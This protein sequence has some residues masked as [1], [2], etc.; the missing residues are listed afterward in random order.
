M[1]NIFFHRKLN[2]ILT[3][4]EPRS[5][6]FIKEWRNSL[7]NVDE[8]DEKDIRI[9]ILLDFA[10]ETYKL[11]QIS[12]TID[13]QQKESS[14]LSG[15]KSVNDLP[16]CRINLLELAKKLCH[17]I[18]PSLSEHLINNLSCDNKIKDILFGCIKEDDPERLKKT[19]EEKNIDYEYLAKACKYVLSLEDFA[20][21][22]GEYGKSINND[23][24][25]KVE[26][27]I[28]DP[29][30]G[31]IEFLEELKTVILTRIDNSQIYKDDIEAKKS[32]KDYYN[33][34]YSEAIRHFKEGE[35]EKGLIC[36][37]V[38]D[39]FL[40]I[41]QINQL[42]ID[43]ILDDNEQRIIRQ[44]LAYNCKSNPYMSKLLEMVAPDRNVLF[45][46]LTE[47]EGD[48]ELIFRLIYKLAP[49]TNATQA[50]A[51]TNIS[52]ATIEE[53]ENV[54]GV[55]M[56]EHM[57]EQEPHL[58]KH[59]EEYFKKNI[60]KEQFVEAFCECHRRIFMK[61]SILLP[62]YIFAGYIALYYSD[63]IKDDQ[64]KIAN[65]HFFKFMFYVQEIVKGKDSN[66]KH[67]NETTYKTGFNN[68][69]KHIKKEKKTW[70][71]MKKCKYM[72]DYI[73]KLFD[74]K[75][76]RPELWRKRI[77]IIIDY[78]QIFKE[79]LTKK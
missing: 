62:E 34:L 42:S 33:D 50:P 78:A 70:D 54:N 46:E 20:I 75:D 17:S 35:E 13:Q 39:F 22:I 47:P 44:Q 74:E 7:E 43:G 3:E 71:E 57:E 9:K 26:N 28:I 18:S 14:I 69:V 68:L 49:E 79:E 24:Y 64:I 27:G 21:E 38:P 19:L 40:C 23:I 37:F 52:S 77:K 76:K 66:S 67:F 73:R 36:L 16:S 63:I 15:E 60:T 4:K 65:R 10:I 31:L 56:S 2:K 61:E 6:E 30:E 25:G 48:E 1:I 29:Q 53:K 12:R 5:I 32:E 59:F 8:L 45:K 41:Y 72:Q 51:S 11:C 55:P 58:L